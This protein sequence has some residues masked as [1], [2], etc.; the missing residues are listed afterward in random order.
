M[1]RI[2]CVLLLLT[3]VTGCGDGRVPVYPVSG[4][5]TYKGKPAEGWLVVLHMENPPEIH[6]DAPHPLP[7]APVQPD[8]SFCFQT[9]GTEDGAPVG[10]F[11][12]SFVWMP[13]PGEQSFDPKLQEDDPRRAKQIYWPELF[14]IKPGTN[15]LPLFDLK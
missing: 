3:V 9:Y 12:I 2:L 15:E 4:K 10:R 14:E 13:K 6:T 1:C 5:V 11:K 8:G 7:R